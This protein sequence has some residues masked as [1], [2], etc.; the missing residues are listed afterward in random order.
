MTKDEFDKEEKRLAAVDITP[1]SDM[2]AALGGK[3]P[4][5]AHVSVALLNYVARAHQYGAQKYEMGNYLRKPSAGTDVDRLLE[6]ISAAQRH[7]AQ[8]ADSIIR[9]EGKGLGAK[10]RKDEAYFGADDESKLPHAAH[11]GASLSMALQQAA[12]AGLIPLDPGITWKVTR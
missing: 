3:K 9:F 4:V 5:L 2:K 10:V 7:L 11:A 8:W 1:L 6:Y 12:D